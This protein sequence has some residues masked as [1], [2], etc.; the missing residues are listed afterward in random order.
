MP[1]VTSAGRCVRED[2][3]GGVISDNSREMRPKYRKATLPDRGEGIMTMSEYEE[4]FRSPT[5]SL[6]QTSPSLGA[7]TG[8]D[9][10]VDP[11]G[12]L[13]PWSA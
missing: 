10:G 1:P 3:G 7:P 8:D 4:R 11:S 6:H 12:S 2:R 13:Q 5:P 9:G